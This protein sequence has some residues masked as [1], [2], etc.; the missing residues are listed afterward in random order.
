MSKLINMVPDF[1]YKPAAI[2][3]ELLPAIQTECFKM[4]LSMNQK[5]KDKNKIFYYFVDFKNEFGNLED[6]CP[7]LSSE[8]RRLGI[9]DLFFRMFFVQWD[10]SH[11]PMPIHRDYLD[12]ALMYGH[13][14]LNIPVRGCEDS[15]TVFYKGDLDHT[16]SWR[17]DAIGTDVAGRAIPANE[18]T[19]VEIDR[20][21]SDVPLWINNYV[22]H[23]GRTNS[24]KKRMLVSLRFYS[25]QHLFDSGYFDEHLVAK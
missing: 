1:L 13:F 4:F 24:N 12:D 20:V 7:V 22:L 2:N 21:G 15:Y 6:L 25:M 14:G 5:V 16:G 11:P 19:V 23:A 3:L 18:S 17:E 10:P 9:L 8:L